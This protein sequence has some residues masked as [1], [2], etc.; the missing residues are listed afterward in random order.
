MQHYCKYHPNRTAL[1]SC[2]SCGEY[3]CEGC[4]DEGK[5]YYYCKNLECQNKLKIELE[6]HKEVKNSKDTDSPKIII[7]ENVVSFCDNCLA[8]TTNVSFQVNYFMRGHIRFTNERDRCETCGSV[9]MDK[10]FVIFPWITIKL[11]SYKVIKKYEF[12]QDYVD[13]FK[14]YFISR[15]LIY[16]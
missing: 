5:E 7:N 9:I 8:E 16:Y 12:D 1:S 10:V 14:N 11:S 13:K 3:F 2:H 4:L 6:K 15:K